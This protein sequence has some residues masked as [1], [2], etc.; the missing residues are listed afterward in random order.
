VLITSRLM[1][2]YPSMVQ[3]PTLLG[4]RSSSAGA[5]V[6][7]PWTAVWR[8]HATL[9]AVARHGVRRTY[10]GTSA[11]AAWAILSALLPF[12]VIGIVF[13]VALRT[14][15]GGAPYMFGFAA[16][17]VPWVFLSSTVTAAAGSLIEHRFLVKRVPFDVRLLPAAALLAN[18]PAYAVLLVAAATACAA[19]GYAGGAAVESV[20]YFVC[21]MVVCLGPALGL[22][23]VSV[24]LR[25]ASR[26][27]PVI[28]QLW[29]W[30]TPIAWDPSRAPAGVRALEYLNPAA[31][32]VAGHRHA[33]MPRSFA[34]PSLAQTAAFWGMSALITFV[35]IGVF[36]RLRPHF[37]ECL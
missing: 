25:D 16:A 4:R 30:A 34:A 8:E 13:S 6:Q 33:L 28:L 7:R 15:L 23:S 24:V 20:Y 36:A 37:W 29:F 19:A 35:G 27:L 17:Y 31:Y 3:R 14:S 18:A 1:P 22:A 32:V 10:A 26:T 2:S 9:V 11:G 5:D 21:T 12:L